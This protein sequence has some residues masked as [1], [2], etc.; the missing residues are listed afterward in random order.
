M[1]L[2]AFLTH[3]TRDEGA[4]VYGAKWK[5]RVPPVLNAVLHQHG[6]IQALWRHNWPRIWERKDRDTG[7]VTRE[8]WG[9]NWNCFE[10]EE[11][12]KAR[13][14]RDERTGRMIKPFAACPICLL[15]DRIYQ[16]VYVEKRLTG[17]SRCSSLRGT[18][19]TTRAS[20]TPLR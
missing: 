3:T 20:C 17:W 5:K 12:L 14:E 10:E 15:G 18:T 4:R 1:G 7:D 6:R 2:D 19:P 13:K 11:V 9:G 8:V 16:L